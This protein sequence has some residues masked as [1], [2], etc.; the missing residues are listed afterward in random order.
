MN[1][2]PRRR[3]IGYAPDRCRGML[4]FARAKAALTMPNN[5]IGTSMA[6]APSDLASALAGILSSPNPIDEPV[7]L[8]LPPQV[9]RSMGSYVRAVTGTIRGFAPSPVPRALRALFGISPSTSHEPTAYRR[10][11]AARRL[12][13]RSSGTLP[14][15]CE[16]ALVTSLADGLYTRAFMRSCVEAHSLRAEP[17]V[18]TAWAT[19]HCVHREIADPLSR[20]RA[21]LVALTQGP[22]LAG[23]LPDGRN[24]S[25]HASLWYLIQF[26]WSLQKMQTQLDGQWRLTSVDANL[27]AGLS[28]SR[29]LSNAGVSETELVLVAGGMGAQLGGTFGQFLEAAEES[30]RHRIVDR[31]RDWLLSCSCDDPAEPTASCAVHTCIDRAEALLSILDCDARDFVG[32]GGIAQLR[33]TAGCI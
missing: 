9:S 14:V 20:L 21:E 1:D 26:R 28:A 7:A 33:D 27:D 19:R 32:G 16:R 11:E 4:A 30:R 29:I 17:G 2:C 12:G 3:A 5:E 23:R 22:V 24:S 13:I 6:L 15:T 31:W 10:A 8:P 25:L 18:S